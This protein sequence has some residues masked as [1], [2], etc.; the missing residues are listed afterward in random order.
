MFKKLL[1]GT[2]LA[3]ASLPVAVQ[4]QTACEEYTIQGG[5]T[6]RDIAQRAY[7]SGNFQSIFNANRN[8]IGSNPNSI[9]VGD[10]LILPCADGTLPSS[11]VE[12]AVA[13]PQQTAAAAEASGTTLP[14]GYVP[15]IK[16]LTGGNYAPF[17]DETLPG[18][19][20]FTELVDTAMTR[21]APGREY[22]ITFVNDWGAHL[23][24]LLPINAFDL[25]FPW[26]KPDCTKVD[27]LTPS[28][29]R[30]C[31]DFNWSDPV[32][33]V[34]IPYYTTPGSRFANISSPSELVGARICRPD[35][36]AT[37]YMQEE[38]LFEPDITMVTPVLPEECFTQLVAGTVDVVSLELDLVEGIIAEQG[39]Q[40]QVVEIPGLSELLGLS[41]LTH[42]S[43]P[44]G[45]AYVTLLNQG[46]RD[47]RQSGEWFGI[48]S[49]QLA[50]YARA[51][52]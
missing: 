16:F 44:Y 28:D 7:G 18:R 49:T 32:Y 45:R 10:T 26:F 31:T 51:N 21:G 33:E 19:G 13:A 41:V 39:I 42:K 34:V 8:T 5:D 14:Q 37:F 27:L 1:A 23:S 3:L 12:V 52:Q 43:N 9:E 25:G 22:T 35:G 47:M 48:V 40:S 11:A 38:G 15:T 4:A 24:A 30:R 46:L 36:Y 6:L 17:T 29:A 2:V 20:L 50:A